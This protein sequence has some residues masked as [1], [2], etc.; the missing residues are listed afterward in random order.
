MTA[1]SLRPWTVTALNLPEHGR[2]PIHTDEGARAAGF[3]AALGAGVSTY[4]YLTHPPAVGWG[5]DWIESGGAEVR[6][7]SP[8][9]HEDRLTCR[10]VEEGDGLYVDAV[11]GDKI[12]ARAQVWLDPSEP[13]GHRDG[14]EL[15]PHEIELGPAWSQ[16][17]ARLGDDLDLYEERSIVHPAAWPALANDVFH[18]QLVRGAWIHTRSII[19]H[20]GVA[21]VGSVALV[22]ATVVDRFDSRVGERAV[23]DITIS[24]DGRPVATLEHE[25]IIEV[26]D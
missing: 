21:A 15:T 4:A 9:F 23:A 16:Y 11:V 12:R 1:L 8:V 7:R 10:P 6:F 5:L 13:P 26:H 20:H 17:A 25:A 14:E 18:T 19:R 24:V 2:N 3:P 22:E